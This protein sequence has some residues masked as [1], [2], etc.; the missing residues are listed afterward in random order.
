[1]EASSAWMLFCKA[2]RQMEIDHSTNAPVV[3]STPIEP[4][5]D[6]IRNP[7]LAS[8]TTNPSHHVIALS[9]ERSS[10]CASA[11]SRLLRGPTGRIGPL[12]RR[13]GF[14]TGGR[15]ESIDRKDG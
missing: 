4:P 1:M 8:A 6:A 14:Y 7:G 13:V 12:V 15:T 10:T 9:S 2:P 3:P 11:P 5:S